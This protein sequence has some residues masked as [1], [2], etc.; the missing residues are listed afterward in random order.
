[1]LTYLFQSETGFQRKKVSISTFM[2]FSSALSDPQI[3]A[4]LEVLKVISASCIQRL[5]YFNVWTERFSTVTQFFSL[6]KDVFL[7]AIAVIALFAFASYTRQKDTQMERLTD[8]AFWLSTGEIRL[9]EMIRKMRKKRFTGRELFEKS[10]D[11]T[12]NEVNFES[13]Y[14]DLKILER[15]GFLKKDLIVKGKNAVM[16]WVFAL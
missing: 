12:K 6:S 4:A 9:I 14:K 10:S 11:L 1:M 2:N 5:V 15:K 13:I 8:K 16:V 3:Y 7:S